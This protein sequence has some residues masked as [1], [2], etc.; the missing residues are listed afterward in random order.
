VLVRLARRD[1]VEEGNVKEEAEYFNTGGGGGIEST[2]LNTIS[3]Q[4]VHCP[5]NNDVSMLGIQLVA[6]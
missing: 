2:I 4:H 6:A 5:P 1:A 3:R